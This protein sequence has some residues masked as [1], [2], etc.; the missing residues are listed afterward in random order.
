MQTE[1]LAAWKNPNQLKLS[2]L[3]SK[4]LHTYKFHWNA[5]KTWYF[6]YLVIIVIIRYLPWK[7]CMK[8]SQCEIPLK[9]SFTDTQIRGTS[10]SGDRS[11]LFTLILG[12]RGQKSASALNCVTLE[13]YHSSG[14]HNRCTSNGAR[15]LKFTQ[16]PGSPPLPNMF[17]W[18]NP[19]WAETSRMELLMSKH[20][21]G[22]GAARPSENDGEI[23]LRFRGSAAHNGLFELQIKG[24]GA[25]RHHY[26]IQMMLSFDNNDAKFSDNM[27]AVTVLAC[28]EHY[29]TFTSAPN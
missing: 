22:S 10:L 28:A 6:E 20:A 16:R 19:V 26:C 5:A 15:L 9:A 12:F 2:V 18:H 23:T 27:L 25:C 1:A 14:Q 7:M 24:G 13:S 29:V 4:M 11:N 21:A 17:K 8:P 3:L